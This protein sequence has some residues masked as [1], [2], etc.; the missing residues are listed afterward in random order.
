MAAESP[1][2]FDNDIDY[3]EFSHL[4]DYY[5]AHRAMGKATSIAAFAAAHVAA[6]EAEIALE[7]YYAERQHD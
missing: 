7:T 1:Q 6:T 2:L 3:S 4:R 5:Q